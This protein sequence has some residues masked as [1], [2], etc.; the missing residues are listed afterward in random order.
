MT[1]PRLPYYKADEAL[2]ARVTASLR[3]APREAPLAPRRWARAVAG[4]AAALVLVGGGW[5]LG[6][7]GSHAETW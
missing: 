5:L 6:G 1:P 3:A 7:R 4:I 2:R